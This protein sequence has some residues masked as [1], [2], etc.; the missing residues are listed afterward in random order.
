MA[1]RPAPTDFP[2]HL[3]ARRGVGGALV[4]AVAGA[5]AAFFIAWQAAMLVG[6][7]AAAICFLI[8]LWHSILPQDPMATA[9]HATRNDDSRLAADITIL[10]SSATSLV[11]VGFVLVKAGERGGIAQAV[12]TAIAVL[13]VVLAWAVVQTI[14]TLKYGHIYYA[15]GGGIDFGPEGD[16]DYHDFAYLAFTIGM[17]YQVSDTNLTT[18]KMR[19]TALLHG[20]LSFVFG[21]AIIAMMINVV[22]GLIGR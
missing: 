21:T 18:R 15:H 9:R 22:A 20:L 11:A 14:F 5:V 10:A 8:V 1:S 19:S 13:S 6:W 4:G 17:T 7:S 3:A 16:P 2:S 12:L